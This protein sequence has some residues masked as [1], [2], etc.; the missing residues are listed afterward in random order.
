M[1]NLLLRPDLQR[2]VRRKPILELLW[3][4]S[5]HHATMRNNMKQPDHHFLCSYSRYSVRNALGLFKM[6]Q[7]V[8]LAKPFTMTFTHFV[9]LHTSKKHFN[10]MQRTSDKSSSASPMQNLLLR[11]G[12]QRNVRRKPIHEL[13]WQI[14][15]H[16]ATMRNNMK[17]PDH[18][19]LCSYSRYSVRTAL[20]LFKMFQTIF[21]AKP[22]TIIFTQFALLHTSIVQ[23]HFNEI[24]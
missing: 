23:N 2:N 5:S 8:F 9:L 16:H 11:P 12:L 3:Q 10:E 17:Q 15:S 6:F 13:L 24:Q 4:I 1:Q 22:F 14:S 19:F 20:G 21:L 7:T 18:H